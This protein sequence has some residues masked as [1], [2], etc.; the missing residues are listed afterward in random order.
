MGF[1]ICFVSVAKDP[2]RA[3][4]YPSDEKDGLDFNGINCPTPVSQIKKVEKQN[5]LT[6]NVFGFKSDKIIIHHFSKMTDSTE[7]INLMSIEDG[8]RL[9]YT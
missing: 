5:N 6:T 4:K 2:Q 1:K 7:R 3:L 8:D 9:H